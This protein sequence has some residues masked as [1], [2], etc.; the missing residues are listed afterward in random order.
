MKLTGAY[1]LAEA[2]LRSAE[3]KDKEKDALLVEALKAI[4]DGDLDL[5]EQKL[6]EAE[7]AAD[8]VER[9]A[10]SA[11]AATGAPPLQQQEK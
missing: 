8:E 11:S 5:S 4:A 6:A 3:A 1:T 9:L 7:A 2:A 10:K